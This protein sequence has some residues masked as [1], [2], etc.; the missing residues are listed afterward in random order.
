MQRD[1]GL[2]GQI[3]ET[4]ESVAELERRALAEAS[5]QQRAIERFT[6]AVGRPRTVGIVLAAVT[7]WIA[8]N[9]LLALLGRPQVDPPPYYWLQGLVSLTALLMTVVILTAE[10]RQSQFGEQ[11]SRL[12]L[13]S[14]L[15]AERKTAKIIQLLEELRYDLPNVAN[16]EDREAEELTLPTDPHT[17]AEELEKRTPAR[18][19]IPEEG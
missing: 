12:N 7:F 8:L 4:I 18:G 3:D 6:L 15:L 9:G 13:Q 2:S 10:N 16:R 5:L 19:E 11:R 1:E 17:L 14:T